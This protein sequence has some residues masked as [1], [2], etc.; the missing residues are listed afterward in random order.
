MKNFL[1]KIKFL[2][3]DK[4]SLFLLFL[5]SIIIALIET[6]GVSAIMPF[7]SVSIDL[8]LIHEKSYYLSVYK[9]FKLD[10][11][12]DFVVLFGLA[13][14]LFYIFRAIFTTYYYYKLIKFSKDTYKSIVLK[15]FNR[16]LQLEYIDFVEKNTSNINKTINMEAEYL[17]VIINS[18]LLLLSEFIVVFCLYSLMIYVDFTLTLVL[19][20]IGFFSVLLMMNII[21]KKIKQKGIERENNQA[22]F[23]EIVNA[24]FSN[25]KMF[26]FISTKNQNKKFIDASNN[27][28]NSVVISETLNAIPRY[29]LEF[30]SFSILI[31]IVLYLLYTREDI[32]STLGVLSIFVL[33][34]YRLLPSVNRILLNY[35]HIIFRHRALDII[36]NDLTA[37]IEENIFGDTVSFQESMKLKEVYFKYNSSNDLLSNINIEIFKGEKIG[38]VGESGSGKST[39]VDIIMGI[40]RPLKGSLYIDDIKL[41]NK[42][43]NSWRNKIAYIPQSI[44]LF[45]GTLADNIVFDEV[46]EE[47]KL[48]R[49]L[50]KAHLYSFFKNSE[51]GLNTSVGE[52]GI[53]LSGGQKQRIAIARA[54]YK[55]SEVLVLDEAT[56]SLDSVTEKIIM[57]EIYEIFKSKTIIIIAHRLNTLKRCD[58]IYKIFNGK[59]IKVDS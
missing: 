50:K 31:F 54:L 39:L 38:F 30:I 51:N 34:L 48:I 23:Y 2:L 4:E 7:L 10:S 21:T 13:L 26:K 3:S 29:F 35:N 12:K 45:D 15:L 18:F 36:Y 11:E 44:Y 27:Y 25:F 58:K 19:T 56:S 47:D 8:S 9:F 1:K 33:S 43:L 40:I 55:D 5:M 14:I 24:T 32:S 53:K 59:A 16:Y 37:K 41:E 57:D 49:I 28:N 6:V 42:Q 52:G 22:I 46:Y 20:I 17:V